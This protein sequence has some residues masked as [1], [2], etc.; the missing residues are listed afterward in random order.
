MDTAISFDK[1]R[2]RYEYGDSS[3]P[4]LCQEYGFI[5]T[6]LEQYATDHNW[7]VRDAP[8]L[9]SVSEI[10]EFYTKVRRELSVQVAQRALVIWDRVVNIEENLLK[11]V[12]SALNVDILDGLELTRLVKVM[13]TLQ[14]NNKLFAE[15]ITIPAQN[16]KDRIDPEDDDD[17]R[18][19]TVKVVHASKGKGGD[20]K[21]EK[22]DVDETPGPF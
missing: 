10:T 7:R 5:I 19:W 3:I 1:L 20:K 13:E 9:E 6:E 15:A 12:E 14:S 8:N 16:D 17:D 4:E 22:M 21:T 11:K 18:V 2:F